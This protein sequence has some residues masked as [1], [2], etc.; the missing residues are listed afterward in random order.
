[1]NKRNNILKFLKPYKYKDQGRR[2]NQYFTTPIC[3]NFKDEDVEEFNNIIAFLEDSDLNKLE[4]TK[5]GAIKQGKMGSNNYYAWDLQYNRI[6]IRI[7]VSIDGY[8]WVF[9]CGAF[10]KAEDNIGIYPNVAFNILK[11][12]LKEDGVDLDKY[13]ISNGKEVKANI[14]KPLIQM[15]YPNEILYNCYHIDFHNSYPAGLCNTHPEFRNTIEKIYNERMITT[16]EY[17]K[18]KLKAILNVSIGWMQSY[19]PDKKRYAEWAHLAKD[20]IHDNNKRI[21][22]LA[23]KLELSDGKILGFNTDGIWVQFKNKLYHDEH[24]GAKLGEWAYDHFN[25]TFRAKSDGVYEFIEDGKYHVVCRGLTTYD[26]TEPDRDKWQWGDIY[27]GDLLLYKFDKDLNRIV[28]IS[29][30][31]MY[32]EV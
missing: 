25:C 9:K 13:K 28:K 22:D 29:E 15:H 26:L 3:Y 7:T 24:E 5:S 12:D 6:G 27:K 23:L 8:V 17:D 10:T 20:A 18:R 4:R 31:E 21:C 30:E 14:E 11:A 19:K 1:M 32:N 2:L 16:N